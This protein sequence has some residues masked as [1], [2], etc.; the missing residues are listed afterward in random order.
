MLLVTFLTSNFAGTI[1]SFVGAGAIEAQPLLKQNRPSFSLI[2]NIG[3]VKG[4][5]L[6]CIAVHTRWLACA[7][8]CCVLY[9]WNGGFSLSVITLVCIILLIS[10]IWFT[11]RI[12]SSPES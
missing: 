5:M 6:C 4:L 8:F 1:I 2:N 10:V 7:I 9:T 11:D 3:A 12:S